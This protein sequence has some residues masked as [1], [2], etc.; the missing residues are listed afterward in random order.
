MKVREF[1]IYVELGDCYEGWISRSI[2]GGDVPISNKQFLF[3][4]SYYASGAFLSPTTANGTYGLSWFG[5][6]CG[7]YWSGGPFAWNAVWMDDSQPG[8]TSVFVQSIMETV[9]KK[10]P[11]IWNVYKPVHIE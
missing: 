6:V 9:Q 5:P 8:S 1:S 11:G 4:G 2:P 10:H 7:Y 3:S